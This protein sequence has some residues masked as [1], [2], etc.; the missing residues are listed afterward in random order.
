MRRYAFLIVVLFVFCLVQ[1]Y[2]TYTRQQHIP[3]KM[4]DIHLSARKRVPCTVMNPCACRRKKD[5]CLCAGGT[6]VGPNCLETGCVWAVQLDGGH[7]E[8][9][10]R[11]A[12]I[13]DRGQCRLCSSDDCSACKN[14]EGCRSAEGG[15]CIWKTGV[16]QQACDMKNCGGCQDS[17]SCLSITYGDFGKKCMWDAKAHKCNNRCHPHQC[18]SCTS[19]SE[20]RIRKTCVWDTKLN[21]CVSKCY[22]A[23]SDIALG[24][25][26]WTCETEFLCTH[27]DNSKSAQKING[28][29][30]SKSIQQCIGPNTDGISPHYGNIINPND[31]DFFHIDSVAGNVYLH[32]SDVSVEAISFTTIYGDLDIGSN[33]NLEEISLNTMKYL[34]G[35]IMIRNNP[36]LRRINVGP[37]LKVS[38]CCHIDKASNPLLVP[39]ELFDGRV[40]F[41]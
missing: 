17:D 40:R 19:Q 34:H 9:S 1:V 2:F 7:A 18:S 33:L 15:G 11:S 28:C 31:K 5:T 41:C 30:W 10:L 39:A 16:C 27:P 26:C 32:H 36:K 6:K 29:S 24:L 8:G 4:S 37:D 21:F 3:T 38:G 12:N 23:E 35:N 20:C 25:G 22:T 13:R 14:Q